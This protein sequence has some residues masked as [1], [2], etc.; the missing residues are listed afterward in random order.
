MLAN[1]YTDINADWNPYYHNL[2]GEYQSYDTPMYIYSK[3]DDKEILFEKSLAITRPRLFEFFKI[4]SKEHTLL[5]KKYPHQTHL[6][7]SILYPVKDVQTCIDADE[8]S[9]LAYDDTLLYEYERESLLDT[10][11]EFLNYVKVR[12]WTTEYVFEDLYPQAF[13]YMLWQALPNILFSKRVY[14]IG[15]PHVHPFH[16]WEYLTSKGIGDYRDVLTNKQSLWLYRNLKWVYKN[17]G[18]HN[19]MQVLADNILSEMAITL[20]GKDL[21]QQTKNS[22]ITCDTI[23]EITSMKVS[24]DVQYKDATTIEE[25][26]LRIYDSNLDHDIST[27]YVDKLT[28]DYQ[29]TRVNMMPTKFLEMK[30]NSIYTRWEDLLSNF[31]FETTIY[32]Y[33]EGQIDYDINVIDP[34]T[35]TLLQLS[36]EDALALIY[37]AACKLQKETPDLLPTKFT[38]NIVYHKKYPQ[39][40]PKEFTYLYVKY[41]L[42][43]FIDVDKIM[44]TIHY[45]NETFRN[46]DTFSDYITTLFS[47]LLRDVRYTFSEG[48]DVAVRAMKVLYTTLLNKQTHTLKLSDYTDY[49][50]WFHDD[51]H[52]EYYNLINYYNEN[53]ADYSKLLNA[54][55]VAV[56]PITKGMSDLVGSTEY[57]EKL[58]STLRKLF[59]QLCSYNV[60]FLDTPRDKNEYVVITNMKCHC[61]PE[62]HNSG[63]LKIP[64]ELMI[65]AIPHTLNEI[66]LFTD[67]N[68]TIN[69]KSEIRSNLSIAQKELISTVQAIK[70]CTNFRSGMHIYL[71]G[72]STDG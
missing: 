58:Y 40:L 3:E 65:D 11:R 37:Y 33:I 71:L 63:T 50:T 69:M 7:R 5:C 27:A 72:E 59:V 49:T 20:Y 43:K 56:F 42:S 29:K 38:T 41:R 19:T 26:N 51:R 44:N 16:V 13:Y 39:T 25:M 17:Q 61:D 54:L 53:E 55:L 32:R 34:I 18:K 30:K 28:S 12:W 46:Q 35:N 10:L 47:A 2:C 22:T 45:T 1:G 57:L 8:L 68:R 66:K 36:M 23:P 15:T 48:N 21:V 70:S 64:Q 4:P 9:L 14:N 67:I 31:L 62:Y 6:I 60:V 24:D 52:I